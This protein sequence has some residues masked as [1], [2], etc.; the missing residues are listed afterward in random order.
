MNR[1][2]YYFFEK[3]KPISI[4]ANSKHSARV[5]LEQICNSPEY[6]NNGYEIIAIVRETSETLVEG[7]SLKYS[8][9]HGWLVWSEHGWTKQ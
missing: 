6:K 3:D 4:E 8:D 7:V 1:Y 2:K 5:A 9:K